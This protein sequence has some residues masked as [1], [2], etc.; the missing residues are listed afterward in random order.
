MGSPTGPGAVV[1][2]AGGAVMGAA[3]LGGIGGIAGGM[4]EIVGQLINQMGSNQSN[5]SGGGFQPNQGGNN[6][7]ANQA[8]QNALQQACR[9]RGIQYTNDLRQKFHRWIMGRGVDQ[10]GLAGEA[11]EFLEWC[12]PGK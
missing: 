9:D 8:A 11:E 7:A 1:T 10:S 2:A 12:C 3:G 4:G 6:S 5:D